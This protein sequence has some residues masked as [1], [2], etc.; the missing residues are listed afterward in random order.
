MRVHFAAMGKR[1][2]KKPKKKQ[3][4]GRT[5]PTLAQQADRYELY[6][7]SV[8]DAEVEVEFF[9]RV[10]REV[11]G[12]APVQLREDF[13]GTFAVCCEWVKTE[14]RTALG[15]DL[16]PEPL[17][18]GREHNLAKLEPAAQE[19][20][21][22]VQGDVRAELEPKADVLAAQ[23]FSYWIFKTRDELRAYFEVA[24]QNLAEDGIM[25]LD[26]FGGSEC[27]VENDPD[28][29][30][31][32]GFK[33]RWEMDE[34]DPI[35]HDVRH[36]IHFDFKDGSHLEKAFVYEWRFWTIPE[37]RELLAEAGFSATRVYW[38]GEDED[39]EGNDEYESVDKATCD[40]SWIAYV[41]A[42]K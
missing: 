27:Y 8:Q 18:W 2:K 29:R 15:V 39:G 10:Y 32:K 38:E 26:L 7:H 34:F 37:V 33:Y 36:Y 16:D 22:L 11:R 19:H 31:Y 4:R 13:C 35:S 3:N 25:V 41:V 12:K 6:L 40:P 20:V 1:K 42:E 14:G 9:D 17:A 30:K 21:T 28:A 5:G 23:N 24:R